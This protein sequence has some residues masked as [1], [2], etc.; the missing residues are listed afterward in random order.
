MLWKAERSHP[1]LQSKHQERLHGWVMK[2]S[3]LHFTYAEPIF[4]V[5]LEDSHQ[6]GTV[7]GGKHAN[8]QCMQDVR[9]NFICEQ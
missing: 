7:A 5:V 3:L 4:K 2:H 9:H 6:Q 1:E 8:M